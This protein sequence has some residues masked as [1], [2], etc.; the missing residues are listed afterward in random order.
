MRLLP[1]LVLSV[2]AFAQ[3][4]TFVPADFKVPAEVRFQEYKLVPLGPDLAKQD[5]AAYM[6]SIEHL[7]K[8]FTNSDRWPHA[9]LT[10]DEAIA[11]VKGEQERFQARKSFTYAVV[12]NDGSQELGC[13]YIS[14]SRK[15]GYDAT[16]RMWVTKAQF[17]KG[18]EQKL[19]P[20]VKSWLAKEWP[21]QKVA[22]VGREI[23]RE[24]FS[25]LPDKK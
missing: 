7:Q 4:K 16:V 3:T 9:K 25:A 17:D 18:L 12:T 20:Q 24:Q 10:M 6:S 11:D 21:F 14:P 2:V 19:I 22:W 8:T 5:Y 15:E 23:P 13:V 1:G